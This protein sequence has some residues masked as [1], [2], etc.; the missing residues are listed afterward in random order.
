MQSETCLALLSGG[1][2]STY[3]LYQL[4]AMGLKVL[5]FSLDNGFISGQTA[6]EA[7]GY[8]PQVD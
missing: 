8:P 6:E 7:Y 4:V 1:K 5:A 3:V 2:D